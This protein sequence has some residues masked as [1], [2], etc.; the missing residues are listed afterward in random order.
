MKKVL[1]YLN[2]G[3]LRAMGGPLGYNYNLHEGFDTIEHEELCIDYLPGKSI[4]TEIRDSVNRIKS[5]KLKAMLS[6]LKSI[7]N[8]TLLRLGLNKN[9]AIDFSQYDAVHFHKTE[10]MYAVRK[11]LKSYKG[12]VILTSHTP[13][14]P[15]IEAMDKLSMFEKRFLSY[16]VTT[17]ERMDDYAFSRAD[18]LVFP[19]EEAEEPYYNNWKKYAQFKSENKDKFKYVPTGTMPIHAKV[20]KSNMRKKY[21]IPEEA[22]VISYVGRHNEIKGYE[23]LKNICIDLINSNENVYVLVAGNQGPL[24]APDNNRWIEVGW[25]DDPGSIINASDMFV[26]PNKET[27]FDIVM[28]EVLSLG[29]I[30]LASNTGG[31]KFFKKF[32]ESGIFIFEDDIQFKQTANILMSKSVDELNNLRFLN[33]KIYEENFTID[34]FAKNYVDTYLNILN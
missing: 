26:L 19:C 24:Y 30:V 9:N 4:N 14:K 1:V 5:K 10:D 31:N 16:I 27:Y 34:K 21:G 28:L 29:Q 17:V 8:K 33:R 18:Y 23:R 13:T 20:E 22:F 6:A 2:S 25:T 3:D 11:K 12:K 15:S 32:S 7:F